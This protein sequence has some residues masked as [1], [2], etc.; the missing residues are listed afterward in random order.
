MFFFVKDFK[1]DDDYDE[2]IGALAFME[3]RKDYDGKDDVENFGSKKPNYPSFVDRY[4]KKYY[5][6]DTK[7][8][9][10]DHLVL[11]HSN[12]VC[13]CTVAPSH[14]VLDK[15]K[16]KIEK[17][18]YIQHVSDNMK[19][20]HKQNAKQLKV[21]Q[22]IC[23]LFCKNIQNSPPT[24]KKFT[25]YSC[26]NAKLIEIN[27]EAVRNPEF[28]QDFSQS[29]GYLV[30]LYPKIDKIMEQFET[31]ITHEQYVKAIAERSQLN[32]NENDSLKKIENVDDL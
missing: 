21:L 4:F 18:E 17:I 28:F 19:G 16:F 9:L 11:L 5:H 20:K 30:I 26:I 23:T 6:L 10:N 14:P 27:E 12:R 8:P 32:G 22:P 24:D 3:K 31:L 13:V 1:M 2:D 29:D 25:F 7:E 15:T